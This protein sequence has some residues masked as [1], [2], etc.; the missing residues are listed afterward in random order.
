[1][2]RIKL[3]LKKG[4]AKLLIMV[5]L[6]GLLPSMDSSV[7]VKA[8]EN[9]QT[10]PTMTINL[11]DNTNNIPG[12]IDPIQPE[13]YSQWQGSF[14]YFGSY[15][16]NPIKFRVLDANTTDY[17]FNPTMFLDCD[18]VLV[19]RSFSNNG[20]SD[21][22]SSDLR[23]W[24]NSSY[25][26]LSAF[27]VAE[28]NA[29]ASSMR[30][31]DYGLESTS[32][33]SEQLRWTNLNNDK[34]F[35]LDAKEVVTRKYGYYNDDE[36]TTNRIKYFRGTP[37]NW[38]LRSEQIFELASMVH[39]NGYIN[40]TQS[41]QPLGVSPA[42]NLQLSSVLLSTE[43]GLSKKSTV[44][45]QLLPVTN[46]GS[47]IWKITLLDTSK[48]IG[49]QTGQNVTKD[50]KNGIST[51]TVPYTCSVNGSNQIS[52]M[53]TDRTYT[54]QGAKVLYYGALDTTISGSGKGT[55]TLPKDLPTDAKIYIMEENV[56]LGNYTDY[57]STPLELTNIIENIESVAV[58][59]ITSPTG[60]QVFDT[61]GVCTTTGVD[62]TT[63]I[64]TWEEKFGTGD[65]ASYF[66]VTGTAA[67]H[68]TYRATVTLSAAT[69]YQFTAG[70]T[71]TINGNIA[72]VTYDSNS[73]TIKL[74]YE[75]TTPKAKL[76]ENGITNPADISF[77]NGTSK[78]TLI[79]S[80]PTSVA[81]ATEDEIVTRANVTWDTTPFNN[82]DETTLKAQEYTLSGTVDLDS[83]GIAYTEGA[84][85]TTIKV[86]V[87]KAV[88]IESV[89]VADIAFPTGGQAFDTTGVCTTTGVD[90]TTP[91]VTWEE[92]FGTGD[93]ASY[94]TVTGKAAYHTT[95][96]AT[97]TLSAATGY[98]FT[99]GSTGT[100]NGNI[101][102]VTYDSISNTIKLSYEFTTPK[103]KLNENGITNPADFVFA[104]GTSNDLIIDTLPIS[105]AISTENQ[106][107]T[108]ARVIWDQNPLRMLNT[109]VLGP[110][111]VILTG[112][113]DLDSLD[114]A[115]TKGAN[116]AYV[117]VKIAKAGQVVAP[118]LSL[119]AGSYK[120]NQTVSL[121]TTTV[122]ASIYYTFGSESKVPVATDISTGVLAN[123]LISTD[124]KDVYTKWIPYNQPIAIG[125]RDGVKDI[126][127]KLRVIAVKSSMYASKEVS[128][129]Y[130]ISLANKWTTKLSCKGW[131]YG[132]K[133]NGRPTAVA[134]NG[135]VK[136]KY[137]T[138][139]TGVYSSKEP[140]S[141]G[142]Y[143]VKAYVSNSNTVVGIESNPLAFAILKKKA[144]VMTD[145]KTRSKLKVSNSGKL[146]NGKVVGAEVEYIGSTVNTSTVTIP[147]V[148]TIGGITYKVTKIANNAFSGRTKLKK[149]TIGKY[150]TIIGSKAFYKCSSL[151][152]ITIQSVNL[153]K[154]DKNAIQNINK[155][156]VIK[157]PKK[158]YSKYSK[159]FKASTGYKKTMSLKK[160]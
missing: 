48:S 138:S 151:A 26:L 25:G 65:T 64:V 97:V 50:V 73:N 19:N 33:I 23:I 135:T 93:T 43:C 127:T 100:I 121:V 139:K 66:T 153:Q 5:M 128:N 86:S 51:I 131:V 27:T 11:K 15:E 105:V 109:E 16:G 62:T 149:V 120:A 124:V 36:D 30:N 103:A 6:F 133:R 32:F 58:T 146:V 83:I 21:W 42:L 40:Y 159:L 17:Y 20:R 160:V 157:L 106:R 52:V 91:I 70:S 126:T 158:L 141:S 154:I 85:S 8:A 115:Y 130:K 67:Y 39:G 134:A 98:Q 144:T 95:Y 41:N 28:Q 78:A 112:K 61:T 155:K 90:T 34:I 2:K 12:I 49:I 107:V 116:L 102:T 111:E 142:V 156:A 55:F 96:R 71:G 80:L 104:H 13:K 87:A 122:G 10:A 118:T 113:V 45:G 1:M 9:T 150:V 7:H 77:D 46:S 84:N 44:P 114:I 56:N 54:S 140:T 137:A 79:S 53:I 152:S 143:Y 63:P 57:A 117:K 29:I 35:A 110:Q 76:N 101:A 68:T 92:K 37:S 24:M 59:D 38:W 3:N 99:A 18:E 47:N 22:E 31:I 74:S 60:G 69:G 81:I 4:L 123:K 75:F 88:N 125:G 108:K 147:A 145:A 132:D 148:V 136:Y 14:V 119:N 72:T 82:Y 89:A 129:T 94:L